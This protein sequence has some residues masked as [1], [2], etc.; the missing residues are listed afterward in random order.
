MK[1]NR[2]ITIILALIASISFVTCV[3]DGDFSVPESLGNEENEAV[4][5]IIDSISNGTLQ[6]KT[7]QQ[8]KELYTMIR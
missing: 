1:K 4:N 3:D 2:I 5:K 6:L 7:I 8:L